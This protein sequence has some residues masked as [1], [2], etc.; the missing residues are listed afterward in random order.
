MYAVNALKPFTIAQ[1]AFESLFREIEM[2]QLN[3]GWYSSLSVWLPRDHTYIHDTKQRD[4]RHIMAK[5]IS[6]KDSINTQGFFI[7]RKSIEDT[8]QRQDRERSG[9]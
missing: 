4:R 1:L 3:L 5:D 2:R 6:T 8:K 7:S 9:V